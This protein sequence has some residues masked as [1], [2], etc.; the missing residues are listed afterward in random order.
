MARILIICGIFFSWYFSYRPLPQIYPDPG[1][2]L[3]KSNVGFPPRYEQGTIVF[4]DRIWVIGGNSING[5]FN[6]VWFSSDGEEWTLETE[7]TG[8]GPRSGQG[9]VVFNNKIWVIG[10]LSAG[11]PLNDVWN[12]RKQSLFFSELARRSGCRPRNRRGREV[13][14][15]ASV[16]RNY[17]SG[18]RINRYPSSCVSRDEDQFACPTVPV[19]Y[20][21]ECIRVRRNARY[22]NNPDWVR[23]YGRVAMQ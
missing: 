10:G 13:Y 18:Y 19:P 1:E 12:I 5:S 8:F 17:L 16:S 15:H 6:D 3:V 7:H 11:T 14:S 2:S 20:R 23:P 9:M 21:S 4:Q 22:L